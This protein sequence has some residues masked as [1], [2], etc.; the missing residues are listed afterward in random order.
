[1]VY[2][3]L[4]FSFWKRDASPISARIELGC[5][6]LAGTL[7]TALGAFMAGSEAAAA[8]VECYASEEETVVIEVPG[9]KL[10]CTALR[11]FY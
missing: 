1:M 9:C 11:S 3:S 4:G 6:G 5:L 10:G 2:C 8:D 7:W